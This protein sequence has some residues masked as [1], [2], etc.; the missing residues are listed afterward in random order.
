MAQSQLGNYFN[1][2]ND[3]TFISNIN[4][5]RVGSLPGMFHSKQKLEPLKDVSN[6]FYAD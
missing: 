3:S 6:T 2:I 4:K 1:L 5:G